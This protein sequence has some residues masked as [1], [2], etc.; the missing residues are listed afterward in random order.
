MNPEL[1]IVQDI[2]K[3][4]RGYMNFMYYLYHWQII[5]LDFFKIVLSGDLQENNHVYS[6]VWDM[7][8]HL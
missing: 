6:F 7:V 4:F 2:I 1:I 5:R 3:V 8:D